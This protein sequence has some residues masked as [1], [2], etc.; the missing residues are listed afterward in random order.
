M[1]AGE[2]FLKGFSLKVV[3]SRNVSKKKFQLLS[4]KIKFSSD[5]VFDIYVEF[6][7][8]LHIDNN[9]YNILIQKANSYIQV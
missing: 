1:F 7:G 4:T 5:E 8:D 3:C 9:T 6:L 2:N